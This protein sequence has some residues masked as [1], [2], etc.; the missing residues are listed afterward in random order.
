MILKTAIIKKLPS[1]EYR[2]Y[3]K[4]KDSSGKRNNLGTYNS[5][6]EAEKR[7]EEVNVFKHMSADDADDKGTKMLKDLSNIGKYLEEAGFI[8]KADK[9]YAVMSLVDGSLGDN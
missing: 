2:L 4:N 1:G 5:R 7:E 9:I 8:D 3:S 6:A